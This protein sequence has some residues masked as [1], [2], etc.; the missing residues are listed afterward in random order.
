MHSY[1]LAY[2]FTLNFT[3]MQDPL[4][5]PRFLLKSSSEVDSQHCA[6]IARAENRHLGNM[7]CI[8]T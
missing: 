2:Y 1:H 6:T 3:L 8:S 5:E 4:T 7:C